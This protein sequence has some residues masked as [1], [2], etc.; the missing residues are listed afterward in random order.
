MSRARAAATGS[1]Q[2]SRP[3]TH[4]VSRVRS[5][6]PH[7]LYRLW[8]H[9]ASVEIVDVRLPAAFAEAHVPLARCV[10]FKM[11][12]PRE[13]M[14]RRQSPAEQ[15]LYIICQIGRLSASA[16]ETFIQAGFR[17]VVNV[18]GG[19]DAWRE[20]G[21]PIVGEARTIPLRRQVQLVTGAVVLAGSVLGLFL[22]PLFI[23][24]S[25]MGGASLICAGVTG[26]QGMALLVARMPWN[27][28][29]A[30]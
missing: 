15:P 27:A 11:L 7:E 6:S 8:R 9:G 21:F 1:H 28:G 16:C 24:M 4:R 20:A 14:A 12:E 25:A 5:I 13:V 22:H 17:N 10:P 30:S 2:P 29:E 3:P 23:L 26:R 18:E 19:T